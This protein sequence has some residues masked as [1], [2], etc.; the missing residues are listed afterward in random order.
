MKT[1]GE[2]PEAPSF[3]HVRSSAQLPELD[4]MYTKSK[5]NTPTGMTNPFQSRKN[6]QLSVPSKETEA[7]YYNPKDDSS[8]GN[9]GGTLMYLSPEM[10]PQPKQVGKGAEE[11][12]LK[13]M[14]AL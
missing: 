11:N 4:N 6:N 9:V 12:G 1:L 7:S 10:R 3:K 2:A 8:D 13:T 5:V 14:R